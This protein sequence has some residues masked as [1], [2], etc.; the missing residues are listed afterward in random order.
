MHHSTY[1]EYYYIE[2]KKSMYTCVRL[3]P[4]EKYQCLNDNNG[5]LNIIM[6]FNMHVI[7]SFLY[8]HICKRLYKTRILIMRLVFISYKKIYVM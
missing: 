8:R 3:T 4:F 1:V 5:F 2:G 6:Q 7:I